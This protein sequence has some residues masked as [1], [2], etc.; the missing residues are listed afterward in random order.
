MAITGRP[1]G[2]LDTVVLPPRNSGL[3]RT[4]LGRP[5]GFLDVVGIPEDPARLREVFRI[6]KETRELEDKAEEAA[7]FLGL[8]KGT[9]LSLVCSWY[10]LRSILFCG[11]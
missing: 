10:N 7:S 9:G 3:P 11:S 6:R 4:S 5:G 1:G 8:L 2:F